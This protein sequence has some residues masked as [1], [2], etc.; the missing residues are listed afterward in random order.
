MTAAADFHSA[1][2]RIGFNR[3]TRDAIVSEGFETLEHLA[4]VDDVDVDRLV[5][6][7]A[8]W[9]TK[10]SDGS[11]INSNTRNANRRGNGGASGEVKF[12]FM[13]VKMLKAM[14]YWAIYRKRVGLTVDAGDFT[15]EEVGSTMKRMQEETRIKLAAEDSSPEK[16][17]PLKD[18]S[19]WRIWWESWLGYTS[20]LRGATL[21]QLSYVFRKHE[22][23][24]E[25]I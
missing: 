3:G 17:K 22:D 7:V 12:P 19:K 9:R 11:S 13:A 23:V 14:R 24:T 25:E 18:F 16:P 10:G 15:E 1:L 20:Q 8:S 21:I 6:H 5:K 2:E 4:L